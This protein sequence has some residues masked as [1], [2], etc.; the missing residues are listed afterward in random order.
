MFGASSLFRVVRVIR[1]PAPVIRVIRAIRGRK[2][3]AVS[4]APFCA[5]LHQFRLTQENEDPNGGQPWSTSV[6]FGQL[7]LES[8][9]YPRRVG[10]GLLDIAPPHANTRSAL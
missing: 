2:A 8:L 3:P 7:R 9:R 4:F 1:G 5:S 10:D 6:N